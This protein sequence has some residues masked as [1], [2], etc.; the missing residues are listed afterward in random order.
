MNE[1][2]ADLVQA[3]KAYVSTSPLNRLR[4]IDGSPIW[5]EPLVGFADGDDPLFDLFKSVVTPEHMTPREVLAGL[6]AGNDEAQAF[7]RVG[8]VSWI[9]PAAAATR[10]SNRQMVDGPS[11]RWNLTRFQGEEFNDGLRRHVA[12]LL[13]GRGLLAVAPVLGQGFTRT[14]GPRGMASTWSERH[15][16]Y[17]AGLGTF[18]LSD[19][20]IT[21]RGIAHR[22]GSVVVNAGWPAG[23]RLYVDHREYCPYAVDGSCGVCIER[24]PGGAIGP[25]G[26]D[27]DRCQQYIRVKL[28]EWLTRPGYGGDYLA[29]GLCQTGVPCEARIPAGVGAAGASTPR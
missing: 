18:G 2:Q 19:G 17:A 22:C 27:K 7:P 14:R 10:L 6:A 21:A 29:C 15:A 24:C 4:D 5:E 11:V 12:G 23:P 8:V 3:I 13:E 26:H 20:L 28:A 1:L 16:A 25:E 9:L